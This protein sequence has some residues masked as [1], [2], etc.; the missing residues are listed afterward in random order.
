MAANLEGGFALRHMHRRWMMNAQP[1]WCTVVKHV[2]ICFQVTSS[3][4]S[5]S[6]F[7]SVELEQNPKTSACARGHQ[8]GL[9]RS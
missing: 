6:S 9:L 8:W 1:P 2:V 7:E 3:I 5:M 4:P